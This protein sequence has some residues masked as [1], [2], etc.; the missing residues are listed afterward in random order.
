MGNKP[1]AQGT[2]RLARPLPEDKEEVEVFKQEFIEEGRKVINGSA[3]LDKLA[4]EEWLASIQNNSSPDTVA[5]DWVVSSTFLALRKADGRIVGIIDLRHDLGKD[6]LAQY[7]GHISYSVRPS[8]RNK[9]YAYE[10]LRLV[11]DFAQSI[12]LKKVM[13][14]CRLR[15]IASQKVIARYGGVLT[16]TKPYLDGEMMGVYWIDLD[17]VC[18]HTAQ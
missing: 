4:F 13:I 16:E 15:N 18:S 2:L 17:K 14:G 7:H 5:D 12:G 10:M 8:E 3:S 11:L 1:S 9:G 6:L